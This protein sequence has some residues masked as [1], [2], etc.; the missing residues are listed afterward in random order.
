MLLLSRIRH[1]LLRSLL[2]AVA[3]FFV[4]APVHAQQSAAQRPVIDRIVAV[5]GDDIV[6]QS[7]VD[8]LVRSMMQQ[9]RMTY[10]KELWMQALQQVVNQQVMAEK[11]RQDTTITVSEQQLTD[12]L[13]M[14]VNRMIEQTGGRQALEQAFGKSLIEIKADFRDRL[15]DQLLAQQL[16]SRRLQKV[17]VTPSEV[18]DWFERIPK[19]SLPDLPATVRLSH[20]VRYPEPTKTA[21]R[22]AR[23][24]ITTLR[25]SIVNDGASFE[26]MARQ[27]SDDEGTAPG[28]GRL[29]DIQVEQLEP[30]FAAVATRTPVGE[31]SQ[32][33]YN[34]S[35]KGYHILRVNARE[36][37]VIDFNHILIQVNPGQVDAKATKQYLSAVRDTLLNYD[38]PF[39][40]MARRHSEEPASKENGGQ[41][42]APQSNSR[43]LVLR[44][45][46]PSWQR[47]IRTL[48]EGEIS[49]PTR[50]T[51]LSGEKAYH[52]LKLDRRMPAHTVSLATDYIRIRQY[53]LRSKRQRV[54]DEW[55]SNL[56]EDIYVDI[57]VN[58]SSIRSSLASVR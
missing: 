35:R 51:L 44:A 2:A 32:I 5:V 30:E 26:A 28:G 57:R 7:D 10:S 41:V 9:R 40:L 36:A 8:Q 34:E 50:V 55:L 37:G 31:V 24:I 11:A 13:D 21:L 4:V 53:A 46:G 29:V 48:E 27:Y 12:Q 42:L 47:T 18:R 20:I 17:D 15:R 49:K 39:E 3:L 54:L 52:I 6:L 58:P 14:Q 56:R 19:D 38:V 25:D 23:E 43:D 1:G 33:F 16:R 45:L 22:Q